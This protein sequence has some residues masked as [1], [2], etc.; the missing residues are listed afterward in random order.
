ML[1]RVVAAHEPGRDRVVD[2]SNA[3]AV[4]V[5]TRSRCHLA[6]CRIAERSWLRRALCRRILV[7]ERPP[8]WCTIQAEQDRDHWSRLGY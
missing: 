4:G 5:A 7:T 3:D 6:E 8:V 2:P 1:A